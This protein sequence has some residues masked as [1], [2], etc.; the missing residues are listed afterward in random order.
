MYTPK[1]LEAPESS[2]R[3]KTFRILKQRSRH[4]E[5]PHPKYQLL[6]SLYDVPLLLTFCFYANLFSISV[7]N[8]V[9]R[10]ACTKFI[11]IESTKL[12][13]NFLPFCFK[14]SVALWPSFTINAVVSN[15]CYLTF[16]DLVKFSVKNRDSASPAVKAGYVEGILKSYIYCRLPVF[17]KILPTFCLRYRTWPCC[18]ATPFHKP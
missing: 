15:F 16:I 11:H 2:F 14:I 12:W 17:F 6:Y 9:Y 3:R 13:F 1:F 8:N 4:Q 7:S 18:H 5:N 10:I